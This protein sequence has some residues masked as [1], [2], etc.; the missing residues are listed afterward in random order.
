MSQIK[1]TVLTW[2]VRYVM[3][4]ECNYLSREPAPRQPERFTCPKATA[5]AQDFR[6]IADMWGLGMYLIM[7]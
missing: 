4:F 3:N 1:K 2:E 5:W 6:H 7:R